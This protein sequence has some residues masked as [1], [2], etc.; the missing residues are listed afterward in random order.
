MVPVI[1]AMPVLD[2]LYTTRP[3]G[4]GRRLVPDWGV[5]AWGALDVGRATNSTASM[6]ALASMA[7]QDCRPYFTPLR[8]VHLRALVKFCFILSSP[9][10]PSWPVCINSKSNSRSLLSKTRLLGN[11]TGN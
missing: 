6:A 2:I 4:A 3:L 7:A 8:F 5:R 11:L 10:G 9:F 1:E